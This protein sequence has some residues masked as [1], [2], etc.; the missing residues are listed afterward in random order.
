MFSWSKKT[1]RTTGYPTVKTADRHTI[2]LQTE[3]DGEKV[4]A[5]INYYGQSHQ[6]ISEFARRIRNGEVSVR[7]YADVKSEVDL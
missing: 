3:I 4:Q 7:L 1:V 5:E 2:I 6:V